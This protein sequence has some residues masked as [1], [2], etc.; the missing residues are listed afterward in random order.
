MDNLCLNGGS[1]VF[2][3]V[4]RA[5]ATPQSPISK[6]KDRTGTGT[7]PGTGPVIAF[8]TRRSSRSLQEPQLDRIYSSVTV[9]QCASNARHG[10]GPIATSHLPMTAARAP[11]ADA[12]TRRSRRLP[13]PHAAPHAHVGSPASTRR[14]THSQRRSLPATHNQGQREIKRNC[15]VTV[16]I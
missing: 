9:R 1:K 14:R 5:T 3:N 11:H 2:R 15:R 4:E 6:A 10:A 7:G 16:S 8:E 12:T 13:V